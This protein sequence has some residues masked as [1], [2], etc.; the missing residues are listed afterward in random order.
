VEGDYLSRV[1]QLADVPLEQFVLD[2]M[3]VVRDLGAALTG[4]TL[5][6]CPAGQ[7][8]ANA[9]APAARGARTVV[10]P[11]YLGCF[12]DK[13]PERAFGSSVTIADGPDT[14]DYCILQAADKGFRF[15]GIEAG[16]KCLMGPKALQHIT[17]H[18]PSN[19]CTTLCLGDKRRGCGGELAFD[20]YDLNGALA[21]GS[22]G[23]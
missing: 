18:G 21:A 12:R 15:V 1:A 13:H 23:V 20:L 10:A 9:T 22:A 8:A 16:G 7:T 17:R 11:H 6:V 19:E 4:L 5:L 3:A 14:I 2:N